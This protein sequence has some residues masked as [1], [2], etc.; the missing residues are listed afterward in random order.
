MGSVR[1]AELALVR[2]RVRQHPVGWVVLL[3]CAVG[4]LLLGGVGSTQAADP[5][6][7]QVIGTTGPDDV[8]I[9]EMTYD[10]AQ[11]A[12][13]DAAA[14]RPRRSS[15]RSPRP[16]SP[17]SPP[18]T[19]PSTSTTTNHTLTVSGPTD[20][21][22]V[23]ADVIVAAVWTDADSDASPSVTV[24]FRTGAASLS[25]FAPSLDAVD[26]GLSKTWTAFRK[27]NADT[28]TLAVGDLPQAG[29]DFFDDGDPASDDDLAI[30]AGV[31]FRGLVDADSAGLGDAL[32]RIGVGY[33]RVDGTLS[34]SDEALEDGCARTHRLR[35]PGD[36]RRH[37]PGLDARVAR[38]RDR[39]DPRPG[40]EPGRRPH[41]RRQRRR[42]GDHR[43]HRA[44]GRR[45][46]HGH[47]A[48]RRRARRR[49]LPDA[50]HRRGAVRRRLADPRLG[51]AHRVHLVRRRRRA[52]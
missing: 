31:A 13:A 22:G 2:S 1:A 4:F 24:A 33:A 3:L 26:V 9:D 15:S 43:R 10:D 50:G 18:T 48:G 35:A 8:A 46:A 42:D 25:D 52:R 36:P 12:L 21:L 51:G 30:G 41:G 11:A 23:P 39:L 17:A 5:W 38:A 34:T 6:S 49:P 45:L 7:V 14:G 37:Q 20:L 29:Q 28:S 16:A 40:Q 44:G 19:P 32:E 47:Q 27:D